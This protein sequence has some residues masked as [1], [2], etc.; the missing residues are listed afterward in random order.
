MIVKFANQSVSKLF[1]ITFIVIFMFLLNPFIAYLVFK[2]KGAMEVT[3]IH[4]FQ[5]YGYSLAVFVPLGF[6]HCVFYPLSR[7][8]L[9]LTVAA[10]CISLY[11]IFKETREYVVKYLEDSDAQTL[12]YLKFYTVGSTAV[13]ALLFK[14]YFLA[15]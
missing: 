3:F 12:R 13:F 5:I 14:Y 10:S 15:A 2:N 6:V 1:K 4:L 9:I 7:L 8:R 11:Y